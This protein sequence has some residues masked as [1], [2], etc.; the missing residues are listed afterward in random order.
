[1]TAIAR[2][3][4]FRSQAVFPPTVPNG[5]IFRCLLLA[6]WLLDP[7]IASVDGSL[8]LNI[9]AVTKSDAFTNSGGVVDRQGA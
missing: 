2:T 7:G 9:D 1:M 3:Y 8:S 5:H 4:R 6:T